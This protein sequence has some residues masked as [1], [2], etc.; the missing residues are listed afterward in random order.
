M[1]KIDYERLINDVAMFLVYLA[2]DVMI[3]YYVFFVKLVSSYDYYK[4]LYMGLGLGSI[5][6]FIMSYVMT[7]KSILAHVI[8]FIKKGLIELKNYIERNYTLED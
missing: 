3:L 8:A 5:Y 7:K 6:L 1:K 4:E 2:A